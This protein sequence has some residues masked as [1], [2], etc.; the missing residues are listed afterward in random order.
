MEIIGQRINNYEVRRLIG[1]GGMGAVYLAEHVVMGRKAAIKVLRRELSEDETLVARFM[2]EARAA[3]AIGH[4][5][6]VDIVDVG[7]LPDGIPYMMME[8]LVGE[9]LSRRLARSGRLSVEQALP[10]AVQAC[11]AI[12]AAHDKGIVHRDLKPENLFLVPDVTAPG[13]ERVK[14]LDFGIAKLRGDFAGGSVKTRTGSLFGTPQYMSPEQCLGIPDGIDHRSD[15]YSFGIILYQ[16]LCG[17]LPFV[18]QGLGDILVMHVSRAPEPP[19]ARCP[20]IPSWMEKVILCALEKDPANRFASMAD[21][22]TAL[23]APTMGT[24]LAPVAGVPRTALPGQSPSAGTTDELSRVAPTGD[25]TPSPRPATTSSPAVD[26]INA[27]TL[28]NARR[29]GFVMG[30]AISAVAAAA[31]F[32]VAYLLL[33][34]AGGGGPAVRALPQEAHNPEQPS[35]PA[36]QP[37]PPASALVPAVETKIAEPGPSPAAD[38]VAT[39]LSAPAVKAH[40]PL[41]SDGTVSSGAH[42]GRSPT[43][44]ASA[45]GKRSRGGRAP[46]TV[47]RPSKT[48]EKW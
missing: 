40:A 7:R 1:E 10:I 13:R 39:P 14:V 30:G 41:K 37:A 28:V 47:A 34:R 44:R 18:S 27:I 46:A 24:L 11:S 12:G 20:D 35:V 31:L 38:K 42:P 22:L 36:V 29:R 15:I 16:M 4:P 2:N 23:A 19:S 21:M 5:N 3:N 6:I 9:D 26:E 48:T 17:S 25:E 33:A 43:M 32:I 45:T 8:Y